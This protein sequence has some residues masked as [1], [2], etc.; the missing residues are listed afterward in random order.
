LPTARGFP[1][2]FRGYFSG[3][4]PLSEPET[5]IAYR[6][7]L[8]VRPAVSIWFH[9]HLDVVDD[10][11]GDVA[12]E[13]RFARAAGLRMVP[14]TRDPGSAVTSE[15]RRFPRSSPFVVELPAGSLA[16]GARAR[17]AHAG[18]VAASSAPAPV[19]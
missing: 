16:P 19:S 3:P 7:I 8:R 6:L 1:E 10:S 2:R 18:W 9:Q 11:S 14:L 12:Q 15:S 13:R 17:L 5:R 4:G